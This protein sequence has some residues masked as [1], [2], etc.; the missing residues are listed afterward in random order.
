VLDVRYVGAKQGGEGAELA[1]GPGA[2]L[3]DDFVLS[4]VCSISLSFARV[5]IFLGLFGGWLGLFSCLRL[6]IPGYYGGAR[7]FGGGGG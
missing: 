1:F 7:V 3:V 2:A 6:S 4:H 5:L